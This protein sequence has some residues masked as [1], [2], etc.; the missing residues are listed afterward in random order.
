MFPVGG[1]SVRTNNTNKAETRN[2]TRICLYK[3]WVC[4]WSKSPADLS[5]NMDIWRAAGGREEDVYRSRVFPPLSTAG[6][7][8][9]S[10]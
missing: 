5:V 1:L 3:L 4:V 6:R 9:L 8:I 2:R 7:E 10:S